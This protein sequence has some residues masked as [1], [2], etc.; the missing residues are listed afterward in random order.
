MRKVSTEI[1]PEELETA[2]VHSHEDVIV[3]ATNLVSHYK[4]QSQQIQQV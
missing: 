4:S 2:V 1:E 3:E